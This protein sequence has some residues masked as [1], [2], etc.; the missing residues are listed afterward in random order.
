MIVERSHRHGLHRFLPLFLAL[1]IILPRLAGGVTRTA[2]R[3]ATRSTR[4]CDRLCTKLDREKTPR[5]AVRFV[6][7]RSEHTIAMQ[8]CQC[9]GRGKWRI[10]AKPCANVAALGMTVRKGK[11][12]R[13]SH[14]HTQE[15]LLAQLHPA[16]RAQRAQRALGHDAQRLDENESRALRAQLGNPWPA[17]PYVKSTHVGQRRRCHR[18][19]QR[20]C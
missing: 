2:S 20:K 4:L 16:Q 13:L 3:I 6:V 14:R 10:D 19:C 12:A 18:R 7:L 9:R 11:T 1:L 5:F 17:R 8:L 15:Q